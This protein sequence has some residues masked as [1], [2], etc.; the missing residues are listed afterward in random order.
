MEYQISEIF[1]T[2]QGEGVFTGT[3]AT[4]IRLQ[5]CPVGCPWCD[6][7]YTWAKGGTRM[8]TGDILA[9]IATT[10]FGHLGGGLQPHVVI[11]GGEP[12][13]QN[14]DDLIGAL[15]AQG[16]LLWGSSFT[17]QVETSGKNNFIGKE[18]PDWVTWSPKSRL[19]FNAPK[20]LKAIVNEIK[21]VVDSNLEEPTVYS[22][23]AEFT[24]NVLLGIIAKMPA[25]VLMPEGVPPGEANIEKTLALLEK[26]PHWRFGDRLQYRLGVR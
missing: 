20:E 24:H 3:P 10:E 13:M 7:K 8:Q 1:D 16:E 5:G 11:T 26:H 21:F 17:I 19:A 22:L 15:R 6:T 14:L 12:L 9:A 25:I 4:F 2:I 23:V 18:R